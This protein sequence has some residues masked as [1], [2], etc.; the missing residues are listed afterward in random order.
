MTGCARRSTTRWWSRAVSGRFLG[1]WT[2]R[3]ALW[4]GRRE[5]INS[6]RKKSITRRP[7]DVRLQPDERPMRRRRRRPIF[8]EQSISKDTHDDIAD[9]IAST[10]T[11]TC[12]YT[13]VSNAH[14]LRHRR[15][16]TIQKS[17]FFRAQRHRAATLLRGRITLHVTRP[18]ARVD[19][20]PTL[21]VAASLEYASGY[22][23][24]RNFG[25]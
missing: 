4:E 10:Y 6:P 5:K 2:N 11:R 9:G 15:R 12:P 16:L 18:R 14:F 3:V 23:R 1:L 8:T 13:K 24:E 7:G 19:A 20:T 17:S 22:F 25:L 21:G